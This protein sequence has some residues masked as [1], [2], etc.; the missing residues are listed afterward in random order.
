MV[1][2]CIEIIFLVWL[3]IL[4]HQRVGAQEGKGPEER[5]RPYHEYACQIEIRGFYPKDLPFFYS[6]LSLGQ[7]GRWNSEKLMQPEPTPSINREAQNQK[8]PADPHLAGL[9]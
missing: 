6:S 2:Q 4:R 7:A 9:V 5:G 1:W 3:D 8:G